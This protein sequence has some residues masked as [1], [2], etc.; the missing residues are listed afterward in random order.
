MAGEKLEAPERSNGDAAHAIVK[1]SLSAVPMV[2]GPAVELFQYLVQP[3]LDK[4][5]EAWMSVF[6]SRVDRRDLLKVFDTLWKT[7]LRFE[8][9][10]LNQVSVSH[11]HVRF[12][13]QNILFGSLID[14]IRIA[15]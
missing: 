8:K 10:N 6:P 13:G 7:L 9:Q 14:E 15:L 2:G 4:R 1:A 11:C 3:P 12:R 5:R